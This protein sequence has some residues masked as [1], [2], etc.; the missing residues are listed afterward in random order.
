MRRNSKLSAAL[1]SWVSKLNLAQS[2]LSAAEFQRA[3]NALLPPAIRIVGS[4]EAERI[5][6]VSR[7]VPDE[8][9]MDEAVL[10]ATAMSRFSTYGLQMTKRAMWAGLEIPHL[11]TAIE[12]EDRNQLMLGYTDNLPEA[13]RARN[14][15]R[16]PV[17]TDVP[18]DLTMPDTTDW[19]GEQPS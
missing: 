1:P 8:G 11:D 3:L 7:V 19:T 9:L 10:M 13:I 14:E 16:A 2:A 4:E 15:G 6:L 17:Y 18:R 5:G 12:F